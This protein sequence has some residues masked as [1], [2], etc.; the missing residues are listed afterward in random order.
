MGVIIVGVS[1]RKQH[2]KDTTA[3]ILVE[4]F[5]FT[6]IA[7][8]DPIKR[9]AMD[10]YDLSFDQVYGDEA[11]KETVDPRWGVSPRHIFQRIGTEMG[12]SIHEDTWVRKTMRTIQ[13]G[14]AGQPVWLVDFQEKAFIRRTF[15]PCQASRWVVPDC[16]FP[17]EADALHGAGGRVV[18]VVRPWAGGIDSHTS[19]TSVDLVKEDHLIMNDRTLAALNERTHAM[20]QWAVRGFRW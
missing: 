20:G 9:L 8:A 19:E 17:N 16:R 4:H 14:Y 5:G 10:I 15:K 18:K 11:A 13:E 2:G 1:G 3:N 7:F 12:R 6:R